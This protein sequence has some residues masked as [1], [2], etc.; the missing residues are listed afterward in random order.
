[1]Q[2]LAAASAIISALELLP[3][4]ANV[5]L[6]VGMNTVSQSDSQLDCQPDSQLQCGKISEELL[7]QFKLNSHGSLL[8]Q[9]LK[10][11]TMHEMRPKSLS[12][13]NICTLAA[14]WG[15]GGIKSN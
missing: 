5:S 8:L 7:T 6:S 14:W 3:S 4:L 9:D 2:L 15:F 12:A 11:L 1:M 10:P 13:F